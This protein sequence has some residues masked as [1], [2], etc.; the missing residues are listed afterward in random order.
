MA[1]SSILIVEDDAI[2]S[3]LIEIW[4]VKLG[5]TVAG[6]VTTGEDAITVTR[7]KRPDLVLMDIGL[8]GG[9]DGIDAANYLRKSF[10]IPFIYL[11]ANAEESVLD[12]AKITEP[13]GYVMKPFTDRDLLAA[14]ELALYTHGKQTALK[15]REQFLSKT[16]MNI[17]DATV[18]TDRHG[19]VTFMNPLAENLT[20]WRR[21]EALSCHLSE[22]VVIV[23]EMNGRQIENP[24]N[25]VL[26]ECEAVGFPDNAMIIAKDGKKLPIEGNA[27]PMRDASG[28]ICGTVVTFCPR[29]RLKYLSFVGKERF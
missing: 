4:L 25:R 28:D 22:V 1:K 6:K 14:I 13:S 8:K 2:V 3:N 15:Q 20:G 10:G 27:A 21:E 9:M 24:V 23:S 18:T 29:T 26:T 12:R 11:T 7:E 5:Y 19:I 16:L 17:G